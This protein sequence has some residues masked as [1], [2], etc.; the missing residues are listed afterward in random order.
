MAAL[1][2][3]R[4][5]GNGEWVLDCMRWRGRML[6]GKLAHWCWDWD[7]LPVDETTPEIDC[8]SCWDHVPEEWR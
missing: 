8:C 1:P 4:I 5:L 2:V 3:R 7:G 6:T